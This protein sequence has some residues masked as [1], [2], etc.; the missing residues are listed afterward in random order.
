MG[1]INHDHAEFKHNGTFCNLIITWFIFLH[2]EEKITVTYTTKGNN[3]ANLQ[4][5][6][7]QARKQ[8]SDISKCMSL[9]C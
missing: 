2:T 4:L 7:E 3:S 5:W 1:N 6:L 9:E 8:M